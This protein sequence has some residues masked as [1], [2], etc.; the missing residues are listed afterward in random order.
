MVSPIDDIKKP[1]YLT[2]LLSLRNVK[3]IETHRTIYERLFFY[4]FSYGYI[5]FYLFKVIIDYYHNKY[6]DIN[7]YCHATEKN[8]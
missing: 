8:N 2:Y 3:H 4:F 1:T 5:F 6:T 7:L